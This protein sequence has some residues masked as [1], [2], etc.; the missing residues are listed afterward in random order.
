VKDRDMV[1]LATSSPAPVIDAAW[2]SPGTAVTT[3][4]PK[5]LQRAEFGPDL[6]A[7][8]RLVATDSIP[9]LNAYEPPAVLAGQPVISLGAIVSGEHPGRAD[10]DAVT[11]YA[12]VG[13]AGTEPFLLADLLAL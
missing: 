3:V 13:L 10:T 1:V 8:A 12:S 5:Q 11:L 4:G 2:L 9:Q 6:P 7:R